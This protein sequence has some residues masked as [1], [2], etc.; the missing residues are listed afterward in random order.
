MQGKAVYFDSTSFGSITQKPS[1]CFNLRKLNFR[2]K[3]LSGVIIVLEQG[4]MRQ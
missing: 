4:Q 1:M 2:I 3:M